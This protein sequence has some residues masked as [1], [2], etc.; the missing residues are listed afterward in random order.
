MRA[1]SIQNPDHFVI[2]NRDAFQKS[3]QQMIFFAAIKAVLTVHKANI[4]VVVA[5]IVLM[6]E[7]KLNTG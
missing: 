2:S 3:F 1:E 7:M 6:I 4:V 5:V